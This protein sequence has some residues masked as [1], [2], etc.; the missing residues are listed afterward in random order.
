[1][2]PSVAT[3][4]APR[5]SFPSVQNSERQ[6]QI[7][8]NMHGNKGGCSSSFS[9]GNVVGTLYRVV[10]NEAF[11]PA[12]TGAIHALYCK[13]LVSIKDSGTWRTRKPP[14]SFAGSC[15]APKDYRMLATSSGPSTPHI[16][17]SLARRHESTIIAGLILSGFSSGAKTSFPSRPASGPTCDRNVHPIREEL[18]RARETVP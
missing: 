15:E 13:F 3:D 2:I 5:F 16:T 4:G 18:P 10:R 9:W 7:S 12:Q 1:M 8:P 6:K 14:V 11:E 17:L